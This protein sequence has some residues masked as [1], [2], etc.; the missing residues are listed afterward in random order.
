[1]KKISTICI[2]LIYL[3]FLLTA[4]SNADKSSSNV[5][6]SKN[7]GREYRIINQ[8]IAI[9]TDATPVAFVN[10]DK[11]LFVIYPRSLETGENELLL[12]R[13]ELEQVKNGKTNPKKE[14]KLKLEQGYQI[15]SLFSGGEKSLFILSG[16]SEEKKYLLKEYDLDGNAKNIIEITDAYLYLKNTSN[17][18]EEVYISSAVQDKQGR[19][20]LGDLINTKQILVLQQ[21]GSFIKELS[22][23][24][25]D[26]T[27]LV[28][29]GDGMIY[30]AG[31]EKNE[32]ALF[33]LD[34][35]KDEV[36]MVQTLPES[37]GYARLA[38]DVDGDILYSY[39]EGLYK[40]NPDTKEAENIVAW[41]DGGFNGGDIK[42][43]SMSN[44]GS[45][46]VVMKAPNT[47]PKIQMV[48]MDEK[49]EEIGAE[50]SEK[51]EKQEITLACY[52]TTDMLTKR[53]GKFN[54]ENENYHV[55]IKTYDIDLESERFWIDLA[56]GN[57]P[58][59]ISAN[60][61][62]VEDYVDKGIVED[63][64]PYLNNSEKLS[65]D[66]L[67]SKVLELHTIDGLLTSIPPHFYIDTIMTRKSEIGEVTNWTM[68]EFLEYIEAHRG[69]TL[70]GGGTK[71]KSK[72]IIMIRSWWAQSDQWIDWETRTA[73]FD[74]EEFVKLL[75]Y[76]EGYEANYDE[77]EDSPEDKVGDG[78]V[79]FFDRV[80][81]DV[82][83]YLRAKSIFEGDMEVVGYPSLDG[84]P[85]HGLS[86]NDTY[87]IN[88]TSE[89]KQGAWEF[90]EYMVLNQTGKHESRVSSSF[91]T[92]KSSFET[93][94]N[95]SLITS[96]GYL[97]AKEED[98]ELI[99]ELI[100]NASFASPGV[101]TIESIIMDE[102][103]CCFA[104]QRSPEETAKIIQNRVQLYLNE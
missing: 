76:A 19:I 13:W 102:V 28:A 56:T 31:R 95:D 7:G 63:L 18:G 20:Y 79:L 21:D 35:D 88:A 45:I 42:T 86:G 29:G 73:H 55:T 69:A 65:E 91:P 11:N 84:K 70:F 8:N 104:G 34:I 53:V 14:T 5:E 66:M 9:D 60:M 68:D 77:D 52:S 89:N 25:Q 100:E 61:I 82:D 47:E 41:I 33:C 67:I 80:L 46:C 58:D 24:N 57:G 6:T 85:R 17:K 93:M 78:R 44:A 83:N 101:S 37:K 72:E 64:T 98:V 39:Y 26:I 75:E 40:Y 103:V 97:N 54:V 4:C 50:K 15:I 2:S 59:L 38:T 74:S 81:H 43:F 22:T 92:L 87:C 27:T 48:F 1:M 99:R 90:I 3:V 36:R 51:Q 32:D 12:G 23:K 94:L 71:G 49:V 96:E 10:V 62:N 16:S 30:G